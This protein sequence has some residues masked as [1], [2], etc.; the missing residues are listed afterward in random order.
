MYAETSDGQKV[1]A[2]LEIN[3]T[4]GIE[5]NLRVDA[6][7]VSLNTFKLDNTW[8]GGCSALIAAWKHKIFVDVTEADKHS[9][10]MGALA[11]HPALYAAINH[12]RIIQGV[13]NIGDVSFYKMV[14]SFQAKL[15]LLTAKLP[16]STILGK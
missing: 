9:W 8:R 3:F 7:K 16:R 13:T 10:L 15:P 2:A 5:G 6:F 1:F 14:N 4:Q 12:M 11:T